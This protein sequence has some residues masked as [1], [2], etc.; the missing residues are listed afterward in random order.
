MVTEKLELVKQELQIFFLETYQVVYLILQ[1]LK[2]KIIA[3]LAFV[4]SGS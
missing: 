4:R 1:K 3:L 2:E